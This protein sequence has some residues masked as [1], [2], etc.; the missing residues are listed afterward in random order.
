MELYDIKIFTLDHG[1]ANGII[2]G[3]KK[4]IKKR[5]KA[6]KPMDLIRMKK[7]DKILTIKEF[8]KK[9]MNQLKVY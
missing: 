1:Y 9:L 5:L 2:Y 6:F 8:E 3:N 4:E 7:I